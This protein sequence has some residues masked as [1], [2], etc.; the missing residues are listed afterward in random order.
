MSFD[1]T[2]NTSVDVAINLSG[3]PPGQP[4]ERPPDQLTG[5]H[6]FTI[7]VPTDILMCLSIGTTVGKTVGTAHAK[8]IGTTTIEGQGG[9]IEMKRISP[10]GL[11]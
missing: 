11:S 5:Q 2:F 6:C 7:N 8:P 10:T 1:T 9:E 3:Q 4:S